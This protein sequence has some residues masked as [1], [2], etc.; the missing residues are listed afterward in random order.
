MRESADQLNVALKI[1]GAGG[2]GYM[3]AYA[4]EPEN[5]IKLKETLGK[6]VETKMFQV[7]S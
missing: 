3:L 7:M 4:K 1:T 6:H 2:G 5:L